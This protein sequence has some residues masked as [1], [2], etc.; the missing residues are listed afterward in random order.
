MSNLD[1]HTIIYLSILI[2]SISSSALLIK[3]N[4]NTLMEEKVK[5]HEKIEDL[6]KEIVKLKDVE[7][8]SNTELFKTFS[9][10]NELTDK[11]DLILSKLD[12]LKELMNVTANKSN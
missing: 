10:K 4:V 5:I 1:I 2:I 6:E 9:T 12:D 11:I 8:M 7:R 3:K